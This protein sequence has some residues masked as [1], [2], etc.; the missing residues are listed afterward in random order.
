MSSNATGVS[1]RD[2]WQG[3]SPMCKPDPK[4][5]DRDPDL[6][7]VDGGPELELGRQREWPDDDDSHTVPPIQVVGRAGI[8]LDL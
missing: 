1:G 7:S 4:K 3:S 2:P 8:V 5:C 6:K